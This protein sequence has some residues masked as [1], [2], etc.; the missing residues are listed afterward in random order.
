MATLIEELASVLRRV[1]SRHVSVRNDENAM[2]V[3]LSTME[4]RSQSVKISY[5]P[6]GEDSPPVLQIQSRV[7]VANGPE[8]VRRCLQANAKPRIGG[9]AL[10][11]STDPPV[12]DIVHNLLA[13]EVDFAE[14]AMTIQEIA[15]FA[16]S[17]EMRLTGQDEF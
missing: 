3:T 13:D 8:I 16:D 11:S 7:C 9:F 14:F 2:L 1:K 5:F 17:V 4:N 6:G 15:L 10:E 12:I